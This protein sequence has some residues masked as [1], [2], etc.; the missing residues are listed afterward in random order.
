MLA[1]V[2]LR[3][4]AY[5]NFWSNIWNA[6]EYNNSN[7]LITLINRRLNL[8]LNVMWYYKKLD[9]QKQQVYLFNAMKNNDNYLQR[10]L[11]HSIYCVP[12]FETMKL[13]L[14]IHDVLT[15][16]HDN[17]R[18]LI[19]E[20]TQMTHALIFYTLKASAIFI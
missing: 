1:G 7:W 11:Q 10:N 3:N 14:M 2:K 13:F 8:I 9:C 16:W 5:L 6:I 4:K 18:L 17:F 19:R 12:L 20:N 15:W